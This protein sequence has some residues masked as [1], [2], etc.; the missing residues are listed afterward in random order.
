MKPAANDGPGQDNKLPFSL[1]FLYRVARRARP[2]AVG[3]GAAGQLCRVRL[4]S[5]PAAIFYN[6]EALMAIAEN[7]QSQKES[8]IPALV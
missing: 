1:S 4:F 7:P 3:A 8:A 6:D 5:S 2:P